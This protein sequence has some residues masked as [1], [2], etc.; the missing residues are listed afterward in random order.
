M[1]VNQGLLSR[2][3]AYCR[4]LSLRT[5]DPSLDLPTLKKGLETLHFV[6]ARDVSGVLVQ[7]HYK[8]NYYVT[9]YVTV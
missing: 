6:K 4:G 9:F 5:S 7:V 2:V 3:N 1:Y 8:H